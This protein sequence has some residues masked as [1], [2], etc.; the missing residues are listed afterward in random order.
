MKT[1]R[2][3]IPAL[4]LGI[5]LFGLTPLAS[6]AP[7]VSLTAPAAN[8]VFAAPGTV[9]LT[10]TATPSSGTTIKKV[11]FYRGTTLIASDT[12]APYSTTWSNAPAGNYSLTAK[13][14][15]SKN[16]TKTSAAISIVVDTPPTVSLSAPAANAV[17]AA[18]SNITLT[19]TA[20]DSDGTVAKVDFYRGTTL[21][22]SDTTAP[23]TVTWSSAPAGSY[24]LT[25]KVTDNKGIATTSA[26][27]PI[28]VNAAPT[29]AIS[30]P[31]A[32]QTFASPANVTIT[33]SAADSDGSIAKVEFYQGATLIGTATAAP[34]T[35]TW[36]SAPSGAYVLTAKA[37][38]NRGAGTTSTAVP[39][40]VDVPPT[41]TL[42]SPLAN[43]VFNAGSAIPLSANAADSDGS[44]SKVE[45]YQ[46]STLI[47]TATAAPYSLTWNNAPAGSVSLTAKA[48]DNNGVVTTSP[49]VA[50]VVNALPTVSL[51][52]PTPGQALTAPAN[53]TITASASDSD[54]SIAK[55]EFYQGSTLIGTATASPYSLVWN[56]IPAGTYSLTVQATDD[57]GAV[58]VSA[59]LGVTVGSNGV[60]VY[61]LH[62]DHLNTPRVVMDELNVVVW[63]SQPLAE[64]FGNNPPE[65][66]PDGNGTPFSMNLRFPGQYADKESNL[67]YNHF[68]DYNPQTGRYIESDPIGLQGGINTYAYV[69]GDPVNY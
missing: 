8:A 65:E 22:G 27:I 59:P 5:F 38:D 6:A 61:Y 17:F 29:V 69:G 41:V 25:A 32:N 44:V 1:L 47:G 31:T 10:A 55:V 63:R 68:R 35:V 64:P 28:I 53:V 19:A 48:T 2:Q 54:G 11:A 14:T 12:T 40:F 13:A 3:H 46:G 56:D 26:T 37:T 67:N 62:T 34:Y 50:V 49:A 39:I 15:D 43:A 9:A 42:T 33:A 45:F 66:D 57:R 30:S 21:I 20:A 24:G 18:G 7:T 58:G 51:T 36:S 60:A 16:A 4:L 52:S 23:Y